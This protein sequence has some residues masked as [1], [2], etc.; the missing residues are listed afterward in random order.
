MKAQAR[1][2]KAES[3]WRVLELLL[4]PHGGLGP[5]VRGGRALIMKV[6]A[7]MLPLLDLSGR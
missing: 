2:E 1:E 6:P 5:E 3:R 7:L 4:S